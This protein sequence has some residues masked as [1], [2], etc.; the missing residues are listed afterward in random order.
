MKAVFQT[1]FGKPH[2]NCLQACVA[3]VLELELETV[4]NFVDFEDWRGELQAF[5]ARYGFWAVWLADGPTPRGYHLIEGIG[6]RGLCHAVVGH[7][8][9][10]VH[11]PHPDG[12]GIV[13][14]EDW[15]VFVCLM[16]MEIVPNYG[17]VSDGAL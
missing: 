10:I 14:F 12:G 17:E 8:G 11:D 4:P 16:E 6:P 7:N 9:E 13:E 1:K 3:T 15:M 5:L 2:G